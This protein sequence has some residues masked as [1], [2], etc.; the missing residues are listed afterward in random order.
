MIDQGMKN[1]KISTWS[2]HGM[3]HGKKNKKNASQISKLETRPASKITCQGG[4]T[5]GIFE[6]C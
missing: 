1:L 6:P 5:S 4:R 2:T 3:V